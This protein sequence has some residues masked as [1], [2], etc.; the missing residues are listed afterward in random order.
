VI[1]AAVTELLRRESHAYATLWE[2]LTRNEQ[3]FL[4]GL[5]ESETL[6]KPFSADFTR[7][8]GLRSASNTQRAVESL[9]ASD[10]IERESS[11]YVITDRFFRLWINSLYA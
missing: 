7:T 1:D 6:P 4:R 3:R 11:S 5:A 10:V 9:V 2:S 8:Y